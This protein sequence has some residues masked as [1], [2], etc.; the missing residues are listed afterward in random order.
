MEEEEGGEGPIRVEGSS[1]SSTALLPVAQHITSHSPL[2]SRCC[3][4]RLIERCIIAPPL[5]LSS[6]PP[7]PNIYLGEWRGRE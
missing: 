2:R 1:C 5:P 3:S 4:G 6:P 7:A